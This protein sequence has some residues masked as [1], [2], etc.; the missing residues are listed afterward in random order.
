MSFVFD[1]LIHFRTIKSR[2]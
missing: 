1:A 2:G